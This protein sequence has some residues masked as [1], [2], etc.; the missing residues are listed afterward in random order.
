MAPKNV[1]QWVGHALDGNGFFHIPHAPFKGDTNKK[2]AKITVDGG[3][4]SL[5]QLTNCKT[6]SPVQALGSGTF[7]KMRMLSS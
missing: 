6:A 2:A 7:T 5:E 4:L 3:V 1:V